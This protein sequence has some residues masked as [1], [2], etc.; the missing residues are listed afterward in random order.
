M[1]VKVENVLVSWTL[2][3]IYG[4]P[5]HTVMTY[6]YEYIFY[7]SSLALP[8]CLIGDFNSILTS[9]DKYGGSSRPP[10][11]MRAFQNLI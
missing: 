1:F 7:Y 3:L 6:I 10:S 4:D 11:N 2:G 9:T 5:H 8:L